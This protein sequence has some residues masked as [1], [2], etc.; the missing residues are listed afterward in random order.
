MIKFL[1]FI[2]ITG[3]VSAQNAVKNPV[4]IRSEDFKGAVT[5]DKALAQV[6]KKIVPAKSAKTVPPS[7]WMLGDKK[8]LKVL[9]DRYCEQEEKKVEIEPLMICRLVS[10]G[11]KSE[12][13]LVNKDEEMTLQQLKNIISNYSRLAEANDCQPIVHVD[14][15]AVPIA[16]GVTMLKLIRE[17]GIKQIYLA[18]PPKPFV[19]PPV[20]P[21][22]KKRPVSPHK[23]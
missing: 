22:P 3:I 6:Y 19:A 18:E 11:K 20:I 2:L 7:Y 21:L 23:K 12:L 10:A 14:P 5:F 4:V 16:D 15:S 17:L 9:T 8:L 13:Y 1:I